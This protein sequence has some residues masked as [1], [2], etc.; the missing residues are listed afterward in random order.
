MSNFKPRPYQKL[1]IS[2][3]LTHA[4]CSLFVSMGMGKTSATL[5]S[6]EYLK[7]I[8]EECKTLVLAPLRVAASTWPDEVSKW[9]FD[10]SISA[11][12]GTPAQRL[13]ALNAPADVYTTNY[14]NIPWLVNT[15]GDKWPFTVVVADE[16][17][18]LKG[19]RLG[20]GGGSRAKA[21]S[22]VAHSRVKRFIELTG[23]PADRKSVV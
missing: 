23:T 11:I 4:R 7:V 21:L 2:H 17:T 8:G 3:I 6:L 1:I 9:G 5:A 16:A 12:V 10:L 19:F 20:G 18:R 22:K 15:L 13:K 14:E